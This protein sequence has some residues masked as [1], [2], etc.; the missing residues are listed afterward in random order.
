MGSVKYAK[1]AGTYSTVAV[2]SVGA[3]LAV[4]PIAWTTSRSYLSTTVP[5]ASSY[6]YVDAQLIAGATSD[7]YLMDSIATAY[8]TLLDAQEPLGVEFERVWED[9]IS[10]L[11]EP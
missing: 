2:V 4:G 9:N 6:S 10:L 3:A 11:Y 5:N 1:Q 7:T 8:Q